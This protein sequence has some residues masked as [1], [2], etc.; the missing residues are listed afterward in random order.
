MTIIPG[1]LKKPSRGFPR[2]E[3]AARTL[4][5]Q[6]KMAKAGLDLLLLT[7]EPEIRYFSGFLTQ[8]WQSPTR[9]WFL[10]LPQSGL[11]VAVVP[12]IGA[13]AMR[14]TWLTDIR[15][16]SAPNP[17]DDGVSLLAATVEELSGKSPVIGIPSGP[18]THLRM[19]LTNYEKFRKLLPGAS[20]MDATSLTQGLRRI[21]SAM[22]IEKIRFSAETACVAFECLE[23]VLKIGMTEREVFTTFKILC[24][25]AGCD[26]P[27]YLV[28]GAGEGGY[29]DIISPPCDRKL[30][31]GD[32]LILD[33]G[34]VW[35]GYYCDFDRNFG[36]GEVVVSAKD[37]HRIVW[38]ATEA[39]LEAARPGI[40]CAELFQAMDDVM[41][42]HAVTGDG[43]VGR[44]G[45]GL[46][47]QLTEHPS[48][49]PWDKTVLEPGMVLTLEPG[50]DF[51]PGKA[52][53]HEEN[54]VIIDHGAELLTRRAPRDLPQIDRA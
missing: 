45:H 17:E 25:D 32:V 27:A 50:Y 34:L 35:D 23:A 39:G 53:V 44:L 8:F 13:A 26:D 33:V 37:A 20:V 51:H 5:A 22:E 4:A 12:S 2:E 21:K 1:D 30:A 41:K 52:M 7:T 9:P 18:E 11:P 49:A 42:P 6:A 14:R 19:P 47:M 15:T 48:I 36:F 38:D 40:T 43:G 3:F 31:G 46:G 29:G 54:I 16:W 24:L 28:G 10:L